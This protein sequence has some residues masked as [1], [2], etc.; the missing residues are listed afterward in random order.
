NLLNRRIR[1][2]TYGGVRGAE[3]QLAFPSTRFCTTHQS[4][5][6]KSHKNLKEEEPGRKKSLRPTSQTL[7]KKF[8]FN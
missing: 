4:L 8:S 1:V 2:R 3:G 5:L 7:F 6:T